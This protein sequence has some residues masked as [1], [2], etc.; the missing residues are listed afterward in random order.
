M[1]IRSKRT[2]KLLFALYAGVGVASHQASAQAVF[3]TQS[4]S[5]AAAS[6]GERAFARS[7]SSC[8]A[9]DL[10]AGAFG[11]ALK[12]PMFEDHWRGGDA[13]AL[14]SYIQTRMPPTAPGS[15]STDEYGDITAYILRGN[16]ASPGK[17]DTPVPSLPPVSAERLR[18]PPPPAD[19]VARVALA[20]RQ[21]KLDAMR[22]VTASVL[23][24]PPDG[25]WLM[26]RR[27]YTA[28]GASPLDQ[29]NRANVAGLREVWSWNL[30]IG[31]NQMTPLVHDGVMF[32]QSGNAVQALDAAT[33]DLMWQYIRPL[34]AVYADR[35]DGRV[36]TLAIYENKLFVP[37]LDRHLIA[38]DIHTG[39][40]L[41]DQ[42]IVPPSE[43]ERRGQPD[44]AW[45]TA[46]GG[47]IVAH[48]KVVM[49][50]SL[51]FKAAGGCYIVA[52]DA[53]T[54]KEAW[55][56]NTLA[57]P[58]QPGGDSWNDAPE[59]ERYGG[60]VWT[61]GSY[62]PVRNLLFFG[63]GNTYDAGTLLQPHERKAGET[64]DGLY[65]DSTLAL[66]PD[67][68]KLV[69]YYQH[70]NRDVWD[71]DWAFERILTTLQIDGKPREVVVTAGKLGIFDVLDRA[72]GRYL[73]SKD[74]GF[75]NLVTAIDP[76]TGRKTTDPALG[77]EPGKVRVICPGVTGLRA[78]PATAMDPRTHIIYVPAIE[79]CMNY[80]FV[81]RSAADIAAG[82]TDIRF[83]YIAPLHSD[84]MI[85]RIE[86]INLATRKVLWTFRQ[87]PA[88]SS[89]ALVTR[90]GLV[91][92]GSVDR[93]L[94]AYDAA[95]G[96]VLWTAA[97]NSSP[98]STPITYMV[99]A[100][101]YLAVVTGGGG[102][103]DS[104]GHGLVQEFPAAGPGVTVVV[105]RLADRATEPR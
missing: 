45:L 36:K 72:T 28:E 60:G 55:R 39:N 81:E 59:D 14:Q 75:Q 12:G 25:D 37:T 78:W 13:A 41:W 52:V 44:P 32:V 82:G 96:E 73:F 34:A 102:A 30:P 87:R 77:P 48:G 67:T 62:D 27:T 21:A 3:S 10:S 20:A 42:E 31:Q 74:M 94:S 64:N 40:L 84:G 24:N 101:Q 104:D 100:V 15:L 56:F 65:T 70:M 1:R 43:L 57:R 19:P 33:G 46:D 105:Y 58:G 8:H 71:L 54:G 93:K 68:G 97:L 7:C 11:P 26:W 79:S 22:P 63:V 89:S 92:V 16:G 49:G 53:E 23:E 83:P 88:T 76:I 17:A 18:R 85:G 98:N 91:F 35:R 47:P 80:Q 38:L 66:D 50:V 61:S 103:W 4:F 6:R 95:T 51:G 9:A 69:W 86:A 29:I 90:G 5:E 2:L 99:G